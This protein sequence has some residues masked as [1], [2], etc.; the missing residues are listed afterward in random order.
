MSTTSEPKTHN[1]M[2][3]Y[4]CCGI[5]EALLEAVSV[6]VVGLDSSGR[7]VFAN[8]V[9]ARIL[10]Y[11]IGELQG[12]LHHQLAHHSHQDR[13]RR[14]ESDCPVMMSL[15]DGEIRQIDY[16]TFWRRDG[17][18]F[19]VS[20]TVY[21]VRENQRII[22]AVLT[23]FDSSEQIRSRNALKVTGD[24]LKFE[25]E[26]LQNKESALNELLDRIQEEKLSMRKQLAISVNH[27]VMPLLRQLEVAAPPELRNLVISL[28]SNID[29]VLANPEQ[30]RTAELSVLSRREL[31]LC[32]LISTGM[33]SKE[34]GR[35]L[36]I[37]PLTVLKQRQ[38][39]RRK[40]KIKGKSANLATHLRRILSTDSN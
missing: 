21:P 37:S 14:S 20:Y 4:G 40:L 2:F 22:G 24:L 1:P 33:S 35:L 8:S 18:S 36:R 28:R 31:E 11:P 5:H 26:S 29:A 7:V 39:I 27:R 17:G 19:P 15:K 25:R 34:I 10:G 13:S 16:D 3:P 38:H 9:A 32:H 23:Y 6:G 12:A 30:G